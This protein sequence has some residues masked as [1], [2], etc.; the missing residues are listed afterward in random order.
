MPHYFSKIIDENQQPF[1]FQTPI[2]TTKSGIITTGKK[3]YSDLLF[4]DE[5]QKYIQEIL[6]V[7]TEPHRWVDIQSDK[8]WYHLL[9]SSCFSVFPYVC[10]IQQLQ[11]ICQV[12]IQ[13]F[14]IYFLDA[15]VDTS[16]D[17]CYTKTIDKEIVDKTRR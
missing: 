13:V 15:K 7:L 9:T 2:C 12:L 17:T 6:L 11:I 4:M 8:P 3:M 16:L 5:N 1:I 10:N 14:Y